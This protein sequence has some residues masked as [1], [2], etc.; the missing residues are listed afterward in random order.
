MPK[1]EELPEVLSYI[2]WWRKGDPGPEWV[3]RIIEEISAEQRVELVVHELQY[4]KELLELGKQA[5][6]A[7]TKAIDLHI[8]TFNAAAGKKS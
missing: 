6:A 4:E 5:L 3:S 7:R 1:G 2:P 8:A